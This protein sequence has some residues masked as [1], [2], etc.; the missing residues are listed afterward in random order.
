[1]DTHKQN[2][3]IQTKIKLFGPEKSRLEEPHQAVNLAVE[4]RCHVLHSIFHL[5]AESFLQIT[6][7][8][9]CQVGGV[10]THNGR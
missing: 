4:G 9:T 8:T 10:F 2:K 7:M 6:K 1:M 3:F 5:L